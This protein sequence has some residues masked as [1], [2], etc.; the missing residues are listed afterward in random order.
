MDYEGVKAYLY[1]LMSYGA[2]YGIDRMRLLSQL[3]GNPE[4]RFPII[5]VAGTNGKGSVCAMLEAIY[6]Q[7][8]YRTGLFTSPHLVRLEE[9]IQV[10]R[11]PILEYEFIEYIEHIKRIAESS[12][13]ENEELRPSFFEILNAAGF[14]YFSNQKIDIGIIETGLG[15]R[16]DSTNIVDP[17]V[18]VITSISHDHTEILG[19]SLESIALAKAGIIKPGKPVVLGPMP[20]EAE[21]VIRHVAQQQN[22]PV[23]Y[24]EEV[25][26]KNIEDYPITAL[27][28]TYQRINAATAVLAAQV[29]KCNFPIDDLISLLSLKTVDWPG[30]WQFINIGGNKLILDCA[31]NEAGAKGLAENLKLLIQEE[32]QKPIIIVGVLGEYRAAAIMPIV[33]QYAETIILVEPENPKAI[34]ANALKA[35]IPKSFTGSIQKG[36]IQD[37]FPSSSACSVETKGHSIV[38]TGSIYLI[39]EIMKRI[40]K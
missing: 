12:D 25:Y 16:F 4:K 3:L 31:H 21:A 18:S 7:N 17:L 33:A 34:S 10:N 27:Q 15:G 1:G 38:A 9:R 8:G 32:R 28:G 14:L 6:R 29:L 2:T 26:G 11:K 22:S 23:F 20:D 40:G 37:L 13:F 19:E 39:G 24:V 30:R 35:L 5:H 36:S